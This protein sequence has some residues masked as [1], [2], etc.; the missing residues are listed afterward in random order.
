MYYKASL[1]G[2]SGDGDFWGLLAEVWHDS[3]EDMFSKNMPLSQKS[4]STV[5]PHKLCFHRWTRILLTYRSS[6]FW[7]LRI[8]A[9]NDVE[10]W[11]HFHVCDWP[12]LFVVLQCGNLW[13]CRWDTVWSLLCSLVS[14]RF[15]WVLLSPTAVSPGTQCTR[16]APE[17]SLWTWRWIKPVHLP[18]AVTQNHWMWI[19]SLLNTR[20]RTCLY[21]LRGLGHSD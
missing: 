8:C 9:F 11:T 21:A 14:S 4:T 6:H 7:R 1:E 12:W 15:C 3:T 20:W 18:S 5:A 2:A 17:T 10:S 16:L 13:R 19:C